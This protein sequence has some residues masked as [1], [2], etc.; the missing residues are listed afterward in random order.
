MTHIHGHLDD[1]IKQKLL[2]GM[3]C[4]IREIIIDLAEGFP[5]LTAPETIKILYLFSQE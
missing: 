1:A 5:Q 4:R 2:T 3:F